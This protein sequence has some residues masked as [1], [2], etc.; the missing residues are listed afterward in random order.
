[1]IFIKHH[2]TKKNLLYTKIVVCFSFFEVFL[3]W[4]LEFRNSKNLVFCQFISPLSK[5]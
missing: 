1:M 3:I 5:R 4:F 2:I